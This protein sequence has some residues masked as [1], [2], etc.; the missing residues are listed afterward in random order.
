MRDKPDIADLLEAAR[1]TLMEDLLPKLRPEHRYRAHL[2]AAAMATAAREL[3]AGQAPEEAEREALARLLG[4]DADLEALNRR[5]A[6]KL[7][8][9]AFDASETA[10]ALLARSTAARLAE[11]NPGY[12]T[13]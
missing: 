2:V 5:F 3:A 6:A 9:G 13:D 12:E 8:A 7:R 11:C 10:Y 1:T 4:E